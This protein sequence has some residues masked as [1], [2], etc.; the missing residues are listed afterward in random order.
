MKVI[1]LN[2]VTPDK[3]NIRNIKHN[4]VLS[5]RTRNINSNVSSP[6]SYLSGMA[7]NINF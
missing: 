3:D 4:R 5:N 1:N 7:E 2:L 6:N